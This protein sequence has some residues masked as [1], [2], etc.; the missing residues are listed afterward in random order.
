[1]QEQTT[2]KSTAEGSQAGK[3]K[4]DAPAFTSS[5]RQ[6]TSQPTSH[7]RKVRPEH[8]RE[9]PFRNASRILDGAK[10]GV[11]AD[12]DVSHGVRDAYDVIEKYLS[13][14]ADLAMTMSK[15]TYGSLGDLGDLPTRVGTL[16]SELMA[17]W[18]ELLGV[19]SDAILNTA[20]GADANSEAAERLSSIGGAAT[21]C[22]L[23]R[24][25]AAT[26]LP[27]L[28]HRSTVERVRCNMQRSGTSGR[29]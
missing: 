10:R 24:R 6:P 18:F 7:G 15:A 19:V 20:G 9:H 28:E 8:A 27:E 16:S 3:T 11:E 2:E 22:A 5:T 17:N 14:G 29:R 25:C 4:E 12:D 1:M 21:T 23:E 13:E 26:V